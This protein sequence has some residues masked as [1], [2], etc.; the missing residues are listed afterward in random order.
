MNQNHSGRNILMV[1]AVLLLVAGAFSGGMLVGWLIP[2][3]SN[4]ESTITDSEQESR[5]TLFEPFWET[6]TYIH[7]Q[8]I[9]QPVDDAKL[10]QG[11]IAGMLDSL[12]DKH[13]GYMNPE[14][15][16]EATTPLDGSYEGIGAYV[17]VTTKLLTIISAIPGSP[18]ESAGLKSGDAVV[19]VN[20]EDV[21]GQDPS[22]VLKSVKGPAGTEVT[23]TIQREG[24]ELFEV[25]IVR[26]K[27]ELSSV[28][29]EMREDGIAYVALTTFGENSAT[30]LETAL[31]DLL[32]Q[33]PK[34]L[35]FDLRYNS[36][37]YLTTAID[38]L[39]QF[40]ADGVVMYEQQGN[41]E[42]LTFNAK[43]GGLATE[44][45]LVVLVNEGSASASEITAGAIQDLDRGIIVGTQ[46]YGKGS[47]QNWIPLQDEQGAVRITIARWLTPHRRQ[48]SEVGLTPDIIVEF[49]EDD[50]A[51]GKDPQL[52]KAVE[53]LLQGE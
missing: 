49:T 31:S 23:L 3:P 29:G 5:N 50:F 42:V 32:A 45:P 47:V 53:I 19:K 40:I 18:A 1:M 28:I 24:Q 15:Y 51:A 22:V 14:Q 52:E 48:I 8:F 30:E 9:D 12:G 39:S 10:M 34:G 21:I 41:G 46:T 26:A 36:G 16:E 27:I 4:T 20:G 37:G 7:E 11:A 13:T 6:W 2:S 44:I 35:V 17:D 43:P 25:T 38:V 33:E